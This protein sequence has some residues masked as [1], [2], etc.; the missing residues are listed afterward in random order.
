MAADSGSE[1]PQVHFILHH[2]AHGIN[3][4]QMVQRMLAGTGAALAMPALA[5]A[6]AGAPST[7]THEQG[8]DLTTEMEQ[9]RTGPWTP[10]FLE[11][12]QNETYVVLAEHLVPGSTEAQ[13]NEFVDLLLSVDSLPRQRD[14]VNAISAFDA[15]AQGR[16]RRVYK[17]CPARAQIEMLTWA[18]QAEPG[19]AASHGSPWAAAVH[20]N[21]ETTPRKVTLRD[22]FNTLKRWTSEAYYSS[23]VGKKSIGWT[24]QVYWTSYPGCHVGA[25]RQ[26]GA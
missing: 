8:T 4:R 13:V 11:P 1:T 24:G 26:I 17:D 5:A 18:S 15:M 3:R 14:F 19:E 10:L 6:T 7:P 9:P 22:H 16:W 23:E 25:G 12:H 21:E 2:P 20:R